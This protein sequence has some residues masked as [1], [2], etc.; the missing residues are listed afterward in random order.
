MTI[1]DRSTGNRIR[2][3]ATQFAEELAKRLPDFDKTRD[4]ATNAVHDAADQARHQLD[5]AGEIAKVIGGDIAHSAEKVAAD[6]PIDEI[7]QRIRAVASTTGV[8]ALVARLEKELPDV[9]RDKDHR[10]YARG[11]TQARSKYLV[12]GIMAGVGVGAVAAILLDPKHGK[13]RRAAIAR[14]ASSLTSDAGRTVAGKAKFASDRARGM[15]V[16][17]GMIKP[18]ATEPVDSATTPVFSDGPVTDP[19][20]TVW[21]PLP[22]AAGDAVPAGDITT[23]PP[24]LDAADDL[25]AAPATRG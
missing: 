2:S 1:L 7:G 6:N 9:D 13:E 12:V 16:E 24:T 15:A 10:A 18:P 14:K 23:P 25:G 8:R 3:D 20:S 21:E 22:S 19:S 11:R 4:Q 5:R 17:R